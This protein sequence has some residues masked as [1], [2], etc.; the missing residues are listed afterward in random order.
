MTLVE[1][2]M[3]NAKA[4]TETLEKLDARGDDFGIERDVDFLLLAPTAEAA[5]VACGFLNDHQYGIATVSEADGEHRVTVVVRMPIRQHVL[6]S[7]SGFMA[8]V[9][10]LFGLT[11]DGWGCDARLAG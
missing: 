11:Y 4:D 10:K 9:A 5:Q 7:V 6:S 8:C 1:T 3:E 2:L